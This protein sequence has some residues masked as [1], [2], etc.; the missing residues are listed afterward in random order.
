MKHPADL[1]GWSGVINTGMTIVAAMYAGLGFYGYL[2]F[3]DDIKGSITL[4][5]PTDVWWV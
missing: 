2:K 4:N 1:R 3:G 5:L